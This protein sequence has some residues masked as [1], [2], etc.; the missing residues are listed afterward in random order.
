MINNEEKQ[1]IGLAIDSFKNGGEFLSSSAEE[2]QELDIQKDAE[3]ENKNSFLYLASIIYMNQNQWSIWLNN[4][5]ITSDNNKPENEIFVTKISRSHVDFLWK[6]SL[7]KWKILTRENIEESELELNN[8]N[9]IEI[10]FSLSL[11]QT[12]ALKNTRIIEG[13]VNIE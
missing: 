6:L 4:K 5:N 3:K 13:K 1:T 8:D 12:F 2:E 7:T 10:K 11:N 9:Q